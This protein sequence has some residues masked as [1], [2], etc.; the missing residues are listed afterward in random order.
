MT[1]IDVKSFQ[2]LIMIFC[3]RP[4]VPN[5]KEFVGARIVRRLED[6]RERRG[7]V[8][9][10]LNMEGLNTMFLGTRSSHS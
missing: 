3:S 1:V 7:Q 9:K 4:R 10:L 8:V 5:P 6:G 2:T